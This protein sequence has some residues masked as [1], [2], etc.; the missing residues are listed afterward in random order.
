MVCMVLYIYYEARCTHAHALALRA[1]RER[2]CARAR[3]RACVQASAHGVAS[4]VHARTRA[5]EDV[6]THAHSCTR[7]HVD[8]H[9][10]KCTNTHRH[11]HTH[12]RTHARTHTANKHTHTQMQARRHTRTASTQRT[13]HPLAA[14]G[15]VRCER[16]VLVGQRR[17]VRAQ[18]LR[19]ALARARLPLP[20]ALVRVR[21]R[22]CV[23]AR[24]CRRG[25]EEAL[26]RREP[27]TSSQQEARSH[28]HTHAGA[29]T[30]ESMHAPHTSDVMLVL[31]DTRAGVHTYTHAGTHTLVR[32][33]RT[34]STHTHEHTHTQTH[35]RA[36]THLR[37]S[38]SA[39]TAPSGSALAASNRS[40]FVRGSSRTRACVFVCA[41]SCACVCACVCESACVLAARKWP[42]ETSPTCGPNARAGRRSL[43][44]AG[45]TKPYVSRSL[46]GRRRA[47]AR[48]CACMR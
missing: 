35:A 16:R 2:G 19:H 25:G 46:R 30:H 48:V 45:R 36:H 7:T 8:M 24:R 44:L 32:H 18:R 29:H 23:P 40:P 4:M 37:S 39:A 41:S 14:L 3:V 26:G 5:H 34:P 20:R 31:A 15:H 42:T 47:C 21:A 33:A 6:H 27:P 11:T 28:T 12:T 10:H 22:V 1:V 38:S 9:I 43:W 17:R 13:S